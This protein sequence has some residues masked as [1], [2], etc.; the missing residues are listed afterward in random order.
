MKGLRILTGQRTASLAQSQKQNGREAESASLR[1]RQGL[2]TT[3]LRK[4]LNR[5]M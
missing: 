4:I 5:Q 1:G 2:E 3:F